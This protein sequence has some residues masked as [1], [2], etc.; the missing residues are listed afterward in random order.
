MQTEIRR[1][2]GRLL[3]KFY[4]ESKSDDDKVDVVV[5]ERMFPS[6]KEM[7]NNNGYDLEK[8][9]CTSV[10]EVC[11]PILITCTISILS[12]WVDDDDEEC[13]G[14]G[15]QA[16]ASLP[17]NPDDKNDN[18]E[19][20][21]CWLCK[22]DEERRRD[23][24]GNQKTFTTYSSFKLYRGHVWARQ[25]RKNGGDDPLSRLRDA[26]GK[27]KDK[28][29]FVN[30]ETLRQVVRNE[31]TEK[32]LKFLPNKVAFPRFANSDEMIEYEKTWIKILEML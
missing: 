21:Y 27:I 25:E 4:D 10:W 20:L 15:G 32:R 28:D 30:V 22:I 6:L 13:C 24:Y 2:Y 5:D 12:E 17:A 8:K 11:T 18:S 14:C 19:S 9:V 26:I 7:F 31:N 23:E 16:N 29:H 1:E 3:N